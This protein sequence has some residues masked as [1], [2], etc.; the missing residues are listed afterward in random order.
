M[1]ISSIH[2]GG[3]GAGGGVFRIFTIG[4]PGYLSCAVTVVRLKIFR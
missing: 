1:L 2:G 4:N 3:G